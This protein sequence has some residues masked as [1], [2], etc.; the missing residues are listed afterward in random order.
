[1]R[2]LPG[3]IKNNAGQYNLAWDKTAVTGVSR[4]GKAAV[5][6]AASTTASRSARPVTRV[7]AS[8]ASGT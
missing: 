4:N 1:M 6:A 8:P 7:R 2:C 5:L 3:R